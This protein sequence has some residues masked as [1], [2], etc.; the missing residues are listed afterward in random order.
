MAPSIS[1]SMPEPTPLALFQNPLYFHPFDGLSSL[2]VQEKLTGAQNYR[3]WK[4]PLEIGLSTK[5]K[6]RFV[7]GIIV[8]S[9]TDEN[10]AELCDTCNNMVICWIMSS[11][12]ESIARSIM[13]VGTAGEIWQQLEKRFSLSDGSRKY[14]L[15]KDTYEITQSGSSVDILEGWIY[16]S[17]ASDHM[18]PKEDN[19]FVPYQLKIKQPI[20]LPNGDSSII[21]H[22]GKVKLSNGTILEDVLVVPSFKFD[23]LSVPKLTQDSQC[24]VSFYP[25]FCVIQDLTTRKVTGLASSAF[26]LHSWIVTCN[27]VNWSFV[28]SYVP[29]SSWF[30]LK[31]VVMN[32]QHTAPTP[33]IT[34]SNFTAMA[35]KRFRN[36]TTNHFY[37]FGDEIIPWGNRNHTYVAVAVTFRKF[38][39]IKVVQ[40]S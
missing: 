25:T 29:P 24:V 6:L 11:A 3:A 23:L 9:A 2:T 8:R 7:K 10:L 35:T 20:K 36:E 34:T 39:R 38:K 31:L 17:G 1:S 28:S 18:T 21:S 26:Q 27:A 33:S 14:K 5:R 16:D 19:I 4:R 40:H 12:S 22:V 32:G 13:F 37:A 15:N 30:I